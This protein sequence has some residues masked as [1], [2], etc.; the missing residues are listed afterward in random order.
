LKLFAIIPAKKFESS[1][2]RMAQFLSVEERVKLSQLLLDQTIKTLKKTTTLSKIIV[3][4]IDKRAQ[5]AAEM[6]NISFLKETVENGVNAAVSIADCYCTK[7][8][9]DATIVVPQDLPLLVPRDVDMM[10]DIAIKHEK[11]LLICPSLG[12]DGSNL[13]VRKPPLVLAKTHY[14]NGNSYYSHITSAMEAGAYV[15]IIFSERVM[16]DLDTIEDAK[17]LVSQGDNF[18][19]HYK[20]TNNNRAILYLK[21]ILDSKKLRHL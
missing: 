11:C 9:A 21:S 17:S 2:S 6:Q 13:L 7:F 15:R 19:N 20:K 18:G 5:I 12:Y 10:Y 1:K 3:V 8:G 14:D 4:S 16:K